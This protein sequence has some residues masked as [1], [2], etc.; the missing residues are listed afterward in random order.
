[1]A[2]PE[3]S[4]AA[5]PEEILEVRSLAAFQVGIGSSAVVRAGTGARRFRVE[6]GESQAVRRAVK[7]GRRGAAAAVEEA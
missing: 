7:A 1:M 3:E 6:E 2:R 4:L 5:H